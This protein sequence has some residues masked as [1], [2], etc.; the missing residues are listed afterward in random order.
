MN[1]ML[2]GR[3]QVLLATLS[4]AGGLAVGVGFAPDAAALPTNTEIWD[5][6]PPAGAQEVTAWVVIEPD[7][8]VLIRVAKQEM[9][10]G[11]LTALPML[12][13]E[14]L[15]CDWTKVRAEYASAHRNLVEKTVYGRMATGGSRSVRDNYRVLQQ[16]GAS[17][18]A[19]LVAAAAVRWGVEP[20]ACS[21][22]DG[23]IIHAASGRTLGFGAVAADAARVTL[24]AEPA[25]RPPEQF[26][27][28]G[29][30]QARLDTPVKVNGSARFGI[31]T[32]LPGMLYAAVAACPVFGGTLVAADETADRRAAGHQGRGA[33]EG[34]R[35]RR[36]RQFLAGEAGAGRPADHL[37]RGRGRANR[38]RAVPR[39]IS[40]RPR[41]PGRQRADARRRCRGVRRR[42][43][44]RR[45]ALRGSVSRPRDDGAAELH[46]ACAARARR[47]LA[48]H[49]DSR[50]RRCARRRRSQVSRRRMSTSTTAISAA[51][52]AGGR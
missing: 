29:T 23:R 49:A 24:T 35:R 14:E 43:E 22:R 3:R 6:P 2:P 47:C 5:T 36:R 27:L 41:R 7:D 33:A 18:R 45:G 51:A 4:A 34:R 48:R 15:G 28:V 13:A 32:R 31:D 19:R 40:R 10:Q 38:Q 44:D 50:T 9:G 8:S 30:P 21:V 52:S 37:G 20:A 39:R 17:A 25:I 26:R 1:A 42:T 11:I 12:V 16:A 46:G